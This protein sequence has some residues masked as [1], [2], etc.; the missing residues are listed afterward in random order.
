MIILIYGL[1]GSG[2]TTLSKEL[3]YHFN[4]P[5]YNADIIRDYWNDWDFSLSGRRR[6][7]DRMKKFTF[8]ILDFI[9]PKQSYRSE[10]NP[11]ISIWMDTIKISKYNDTN[12]LFERQTHNN[13]I[14]ITQWIGLN[15]LR[16]SLEDFNPGIKDIQS[17]LNGP[18]QKLVK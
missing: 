11:N 9:C 13:V 10:I 15:Q 7:L 2:K 3:S 4:I 18:F 1:P 12:D 14:R 17:Y 5:H 16:N 6:Q 8:G